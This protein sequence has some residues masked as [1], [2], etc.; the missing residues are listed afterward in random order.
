MDMES[1]HEQRRGFVKLLDPTFLDCS[2]SPPNSPSLP[3][4]V[5]EHRMLQWC[6]VRGNNNLGFKEF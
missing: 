2:L 3:T 1:I 6:S 4:P 5:R